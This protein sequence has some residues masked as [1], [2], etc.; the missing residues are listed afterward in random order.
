[1]VAITYVI[2]ASEAQLVHPLLLFFG[3]LLNY[4]T[5]LLLCLSIGTY[6]STTDQWDMDFTLCTA[7]VGWILRFYVMLQNWI[8][9]ALY[10]IAQESIV[11]KILCT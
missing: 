1:M 5:T 4:F 2:S 7:E 10:Y 6:G 9:N 3:L 8:R 11:F